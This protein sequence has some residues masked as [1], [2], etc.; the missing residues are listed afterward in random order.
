[1][2]KTCIHANGD[3]IL[4]L[5]FP[6]RFVNVDRT[7]IVVRDCYEA[8]AHY[9]ILYDSLVRI[10]RVPMHTTR[11]LAQFN[12]AIHVL[13]QLMFTT[14]YVCVSMKLRP[15]TERRWLSSG[16]VFFLIGLRPP[17]VIQHLPSSFSLSP[18]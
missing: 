1:M 15:P 10:S 9:P 16:F 12:T 17:A 13:N 14:T 3:T 4:F 8:T 5:L 18:I 6:L 7:D 11:A 2:V